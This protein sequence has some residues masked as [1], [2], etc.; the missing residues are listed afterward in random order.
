MLLS[1]NQ[2]KIANFLSAF[3]ES[4]KSLEY[5][6]KRDEPPKLLVSEIVHCKKRGY[7]NAEKDPCQNSYGQ[8]TC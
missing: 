1:P 3:P 6:E 4:T 2:Q 8:S 7:L 5:F